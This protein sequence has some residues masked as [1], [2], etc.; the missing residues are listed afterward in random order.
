MGQ[1]QGRENFFTELDEL[2]GRLERLE[3]SVGKV[4][5]AN[6]ATSLLQGAWVIA[7][8]LYRPP[9]YYHGIDGRVW[10]AGRVKG[11]SAGSVV[12]QLPNGY[13]P[14]YVV[15]QATIANDALARVEV[16]TTGNVTFQLGTASTYLDLDGISYR[17][18]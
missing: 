14:S 1:G 3:R 11:G 15:S 5:G 10:L 4:E 13:R 18:T 17:V 8:G 12:F 2:N 9:V 16:G 6:D 7:G